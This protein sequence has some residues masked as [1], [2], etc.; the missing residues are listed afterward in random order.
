MNQAQ[1]ETSCVLLYFIIKLHFIA[2]YTDDLLKIQLL[3][4]WFL[5]MAVGTP[6][7]NHPEISNS[8]E[9]HT[10]PQTF[11]TIHQAATLKLLTLLNSLKT[12]WQVK[13]ELVNRN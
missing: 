5:K 2:K 7:I 8:I 12:L 10:A 11:K 3:D 1:L 4:I 13:H 6:T 9:E